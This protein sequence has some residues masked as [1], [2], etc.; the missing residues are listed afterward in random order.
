MRVL[1]HITLKSKI[2]LLNYSGICYTEKYWSYGPRLCTPCKKILRAPLQISFACWQ[3]ATNSALH[4]PW[5]FLP[6]EGP[7]RGR[8]GEKKRKGGEKNTPRNT[9]M[10]MAFRGRPQAW[11]GGTL[12]P[13]G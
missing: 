13:S 8:V 1:S 6:F 7:L 11:A 9:F 12:S 10:V 5:Q 4:I 3:V 2:H